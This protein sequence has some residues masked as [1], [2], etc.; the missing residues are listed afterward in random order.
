[1]VG[2]RAMC[3]VSCVVCACISLNA[4]RFDGTDNGP[5]NGRN[6]PRSTP[7][8]IQRQ[9]CRLNLALDRLGC[10][11]PVHAGAR[12]LESR[13]HAPFIMGLAQNTAH[14][15]PRTPSSDA[16]D[17]SEEP[18]ADPSSH[19]CLLRSIRSTD[20]STTRCHSALGTVARSR[21]H[22]V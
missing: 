14:A 13:S 8:S 4:R 1:M 22:F 15:T 6:D 2:D 7:Q 21:V 9:L 19:A 11:F 20:R 5:D 17:E 12:K 10:R 3:F 16:S 18:Q